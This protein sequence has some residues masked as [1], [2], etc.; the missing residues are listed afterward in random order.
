M[1]KAEIMEKLASQEE[2][3]EAL[4]LGL[5]KIQDLLTDV[6]AR[7]PT[8]QELLNQQTSGYARGR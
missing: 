5:E 3:I 1:T 4:E 7:W 8:I 2:K 6:L